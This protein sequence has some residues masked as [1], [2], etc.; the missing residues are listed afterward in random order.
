MAAKLGREQT[1][2]PLVAALSE[3]EKVL[4]GFGQKTEKKRGG[5]SKYTGVSF[6]KGCKARPWLAQ[7]RANGRHNPLGR[8]ADEDEA[9]RQVDLFRARAGK[10]PLNVDLLAA[11]TAAK[12]ASAASKASKAMSALDC[13]TDSDDD[14]WTAALP[15]APQPKKRRKRDR[16]ADEDSTTSKYHGVEWY[17]GK[18]MWQVRI[19]GH[20]L[21]CY[22]EEVDAARRADEVWKAK[23]YPAPNEA[24]IL[25]TNG[26]SRSAN[27]VCFLGLGA[28]RQRQERPSAK[29]ARSALSD[30]LWAKERQRQERPSAKDAR[31]AL[32]SPPGDLPK[33][34]KKLRQASSGL[35]LDDSEADEWDECEDEDE[36]E[37]SGGGGGGWGG[38]REGW[39]DNSDSDS[40]IDCGDSDGRD[41]DGSDAA[42]APERDGNNYVAKCCSC[43]LKRAFA[44]PW[45]PG[46]DFYCEYLSGAT[47]GE[48]STRAGGRDP[49]PRTYD[50]GFA[51]PSTGAE[52][53]VC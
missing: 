7:A 9:A 52:G 19:G 34:P 17:K 44:T 1:N 4:G 6:A 38:G 8:Y 45:P 16:A 28:K 40:E 27:Q 39:D 21:G 49:P 48:E 47:C 20:T 36:D 32:S 31:S 42:A 2:G 5:T 22:I 15:P 50:D 26:A 25:A 13:E 24:A 37:G 33:P 11:S 23:G 3:Y 10:P 41:S 18:R 51:Q 35:D 30:E 46:E 14:T 29:D 53:G 12:A 43:L